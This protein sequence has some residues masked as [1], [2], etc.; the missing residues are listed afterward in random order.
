MG[1]VLEFKSCNAL[2]VILELIYNQNQLLAYERNQ[3]YKLAY[4]LKLTNYALLTKFFEFG[5]P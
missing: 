5:W 3:C 1:V 2:P 4:Y